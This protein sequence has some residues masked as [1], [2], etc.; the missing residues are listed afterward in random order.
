MLLCLPLVVQADTHI[1]TKAT[2]SAFVM[3]GD[4][5][6]ATEI[7]S[8]IWMGE[9]MA[10]MNM[11]TASVLIDM[12]NSVM[13]MIMH[14]NKTY[15]EMPIGSMDEMLAA[16]GVEGDDEQVAASLEM[17]KNMMGQMEFTVTPTEETQTIGDY[18]CTRFDVAMNM[19][20]MNMTSQVWASEEI[21][22]D[23]SVYFRLSNA[24]MAMFPGFEEAIT[25]WKKIKGFP[26]LQT[27]AM[28]IMGQSV[29]SRSELISIE[30]VDPPEGIYDKP[31][32]YKK[33]AFNPMGG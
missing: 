2:T 23:M 11:D 5:I 4:T 29:E 18:Q 7:I 12:Q 9:H 20:M 8:D 26:V 28:T 3:M 22:C 30:N 32:T 10:L 6:P 16:M 33:T 31:T 25:E 15:T 17:M 21:E 13:Y 14:T 19:M 1:V 27:T 24:M